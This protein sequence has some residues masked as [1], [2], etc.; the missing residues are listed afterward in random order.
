MEK[1]D[2]L[3][4]GGGPGGLACATLLAQHGM[5]VL[6][7]ERKPVIGPKVCA[8]GITWHGLLR[9]VPEHLIERAFPEQVVVSDHQHLLIRESQPM[10]ATVSRERLGEWMAAQAKS[11]GVSIMT[12]TRL[13][14]AHAQQATL[15]NTHTGQIH[16]HYEHLVGA[17]G[18]N[19]RVRRLFGVPTQCTGI[20]L[21]VMIP[22]DFLKMEWHLCQHLFGC[23]YGW[24]FPHADRCSVGAYADRRSMTAPQLKTRLL[25]WAGERQ[26]R[27]PPEQIRAG[28]VNYDYRGLRF[29]GGYL[30]GDA[31]GL[32]SGL[33][34]EGIYPALMSGQMAARLILG[35]IT[36]SPSFARIVQRQRMHR[37][38]ASFAARHPRTG[39]LLLECSLLLLRSHL[40]NFHHLEMTD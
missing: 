35:D 10:I 31:A 23:G 24:I 36:P 3:V 25:R 21:N 14:T 28:L 32:T 20:G 30:V 13:V 4:V 26:L 19:S 6:V 39:S 38:M 33:T 22:G 34:G 37:R 17:D 1:T 7:V 18:A 11:A 9:L 2:V 29:P 15:N 12:D 27:L 16:I 8:G 40:I 5:R